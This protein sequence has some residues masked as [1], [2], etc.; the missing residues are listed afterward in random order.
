MVM[1][2]YHDQHHDVCMSTSK[3]T[4]AGGEYGEIILLLSW[5]GVLHYRYI[6]RLCN[7][8]GELHWIRKPTS[9]PV[10]PILRQ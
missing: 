7:C 3:T 9:Q 4:K 10:K 1:P 5:I 6:I 8:T 2:F